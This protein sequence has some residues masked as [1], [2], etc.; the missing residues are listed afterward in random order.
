MPI[1]ETDQ[2]DPTDSSAPA[3]ADA[4][5]Q[6][7]PGP[8]AADT[9]TDTFAVRIIADPG[10]PTTSVERI[11]DRLTDRLSAEAG[12]SSLGV[13]SEPLTL[14]PDGALLVPEL[15]ERT[16]DDSS[17]VVV[18][19]EFPRMQNGRGLVL[20]VDHRTSTVLVSL[21]AL[22]LDLAR[23]LASV[24]VAGVRRLRDPTAPSSVRGSSWRSGDDGPDGHPVGGSSTSA[25]ERHTE[26]LTSDRILGRVRMV[27]GMV[28]GNRPWRL[29]PTLTGL[30][31]A[32][33]ATA[34]FGVFYSSIWSMANAL[35]PFRL[36]VLSALSMTV[37]TVWLIANNRLWERR[38]ALP[39][40]R[41]RL[42]NAATA[43]T[44][45][46]NAVFLY[47]GLFIGTLAASFAV[48]DD[49]Y[50]AQQLSI[51]SAGVKNY[52]MLAW[53]ATTMGMVAGAVGSS[54]DSYE[55]ILHA[56]Y[57]YRERARRRREEERQR[58]IEAA[59]EP[60]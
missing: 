47:A 37:M 23:Q 24:I 59:R 3:V 52:V 60:R 51:D 56:T 22:G 44:V 25:N 33:A 38:G 11:R 42:Y 35:S 45:L 49:G 30:M 1:H 50:L 17:A 46:L 8:T 48:I 16:R 15:V 41:A 21:P 4:A 55:D 32:A 26:F 10:P 34:S 18:V 12:V 57:G 6:S 58:D 19:T 5:E 2:P 53:L 29:I 43:S 31:A 7:A 14:G 28:R 36:A 54:A 9:Y 13:V 20:E 27:A 40:L 39:R